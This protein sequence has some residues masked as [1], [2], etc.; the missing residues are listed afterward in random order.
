MRRKNFYQEDVF[1]N[2]FAVILNPNDK[3]RQCCK[4]VFIVHGAMSLVNDQ[5]GAD[6]ESFGGGDVILN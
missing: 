1:V 2:N 3:T 4:N 5:T 6:P